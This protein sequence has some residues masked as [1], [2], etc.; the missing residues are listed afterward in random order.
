METGP[1]A[2]LT[3]FPVL[4]TRSLDEARDAVT[5]I[6]LEHELTAPTDHLEMTL[7]AVTD[8]RFTLGYLTYRSA[9]K[10]VMPATE[11]NYH[12][13]LTVAGRTDA[14]RTDG[15]RASTHGGRSGIVLAPDQRNTVRWSPDAE[16]LILKIPRRSLETHL[17]DLLGR[18][19]T[20]IVDF[21]FALDLSTGQGTTLLSSV[22]FL[23]RELDRPGGL[24]ELP[25][26]REQ[27]EAFVMTQLLHTGRHQYSDDLR[28]PAEPLRHGRLQP[29]LDYMEQHADEPL[30]PQELARVGCMSVRTLHAS[31]QQALGESPMS[32][33]R[34]IRLDHVRAELLRSDPSVT[35]VTDVAVRWG[36]LHQSRFAQQYRERFGELPRDTLRA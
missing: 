14:D 22:E 11:D 4:G 2:L 12:V 30:T 19:V 25:L 21:D 5:R 20:D 24:A 8:R 16:Q 7:N 28:A 23:A 9:A 32:H 1:P 27:F 29:V 26:A 17:G 10:L 33:L 13:N 3:R 34:R 15:G 6:Y 18:P 36:F 35:L 31:F